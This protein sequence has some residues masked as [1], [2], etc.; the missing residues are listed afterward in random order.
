MP[1]I[2]PNPLLTTCLNIQSRH[3]K[4]RVDYSSAGLWDG[5]TEIPFTSSGSFGPLS[6]YINPYLT[7]VREQGYSVGSLYEQVH[8]L[9]VCDRWMNRTGGDVCDLDE[10]A[11]QDC[12][13]R[14]N[15]HG[16]AKM[17]DYKLC[18]GC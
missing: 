3:K 18:D 10:D 4:L 14:A 15:R 7:E 1:P 9:K 2:S 13:Q 17:L 5:L 11:M 12:W 16:T 8:L 6:P